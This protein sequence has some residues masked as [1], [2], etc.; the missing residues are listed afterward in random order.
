MMMV[1][2]N[3][4]QD[5]QK[6]FWAEAVSCSNWLE[7]LT[8]KAGRS[9]PALASWSH[10]PIQKWIKALVQFGRLAVVNKRKKLKAKMD[11]KGYPAMMVGYAHNHGPGTYRM[12]NPKT[13]MIIMSRDVKWM[14]YK[15]KSI[16]KSFDLFEPGIDRVSTKYAL[17]GG[18]NEILENS[19]LSSC[20][21]DDSS[22]DS[23]TS[24]CIT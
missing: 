22:I 15:P 4:T 8:I 21:S 2:A 14:D 24:R 20:K 19:S 13:N 7:D 6:L 18:E 12:F 1:D 16:E 11:E 10:V 17:K 3:L 5:S 23:T 9:E